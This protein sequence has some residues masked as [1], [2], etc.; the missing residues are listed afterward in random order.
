MHAD[1]H[2]L[3]HAVTQTQTNNQQT[4]AFQHKPKRTCILTPPAPALTRLHACKSGGREDGCL[5]GYVGAC[6]PA[7]FWGF[8][9]VCV[10]QQSAAL[11]LVLRHQ[12]PQDS[13]VN[14]GAA[15]ARSDTRRLAFRSQASL[16]SSNALAVRS[17]EGP[18]CPL[19][20]T[21]AGSPPSVG[22]L[23]GLSLSVS[24]SRIVSLLSRCLSRP[25]LASFTAYRQ[26]PSAILGSC[27]FTV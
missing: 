26:R 17:H 19:R 4:H 27:L 15:A 10:A 5:C 11:L 24:L 9:F 14:S 18:G 16:V 12:P 2:Q 3:T 22:P 20:G 8:L 13:G 7:L 23:A 1:T 6:L 25:L 21:A